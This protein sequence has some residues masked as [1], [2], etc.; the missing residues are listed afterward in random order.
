MRLVFAEGENQSLVTFEL[1]SMP[2]GG[3]GYFL[4]YNDGRSGPTNGFFGSEGRAEFFRRLLESFS[5]VT[6]KW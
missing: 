1:K 3:K 2:H 4:E 5:V 6:W